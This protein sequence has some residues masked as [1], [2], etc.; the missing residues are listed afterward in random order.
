[1]GSA[2]SIISRQLSADEELYLRRLRAEE[3]FCL[4]HG[5]RSPVLFCYRCKTM[6]NQIDRCLTHHPRSFF[7]PK[8]G[9]IKLPESQMYYENDEMTSLT[10]IDAPDEQ[11]GGIIDGYNP[12]PSLLLVNESQI[13]RKMMC[14]LIS[15]YCSE[16]HEAKTVVDS[17]S[18]VRRSIEQRKPIDIVVLN[19]YYPS[20]LD[21]VNGVKTP[22]E[23]I[24]EAG[25]KGVIFVCISCE[26]Q[27]DII[28]FLGDA[29]DG[30]FF[31]PYVQVILK[32]WLL[33]HR[34]FKE[35]LKSI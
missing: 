5:N 34:D 18:I 9:I 15:E 28:N 4:K 24:K 1:M 14:A 13:F 22:I 25:Y 11:E 3:L 26:V 7:T 27:S 30:L 8:H 10:L 6:V 21:I 2:S 16:L 17:L 32:K 35:F 23:L 33:H 19:E 20:Q 31:K 12:L 29:A